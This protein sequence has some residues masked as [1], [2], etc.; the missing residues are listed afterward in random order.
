MCVHIS[1]GMHVCV[2]WESDARCLYPCVAYFVR[3]AFSLKLELAILARLTGEP[4][5]SSV[6][7]PLFL[8]PHP[9]SQ[10]LD[11]RHVLLP[12]VI[13]WMLETQT[14]GLMLANTLPTPHLPSLSHNLLIRIIFKTFLSSIR[15]SLHLK[16]KCTNCSWLTVCYMQV[17]PP[18]LQLC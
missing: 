8:L 1:T 18:L 14:Q 16:K 11:Y 6:S 2:D 10:C 17:F 9:R 15:I 3:Q 13:V 5:H 4:V 12:L 7:L